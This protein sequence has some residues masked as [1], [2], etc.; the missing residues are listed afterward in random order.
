MAIDGYTIVDVGSDSEWVEPIDFAE[1]ADGDNQT[2]P[3]TNALQTGVLSGD[4]LVLTDSA[5]AL[6]S[7]WWSWT[8]ITTDVSARNDSANLAAFKVSVHVGGVGEIAYITGFLFPGGE[9]SLSPGTAGPAGVWN[10]PAPLEIRAEL[11]QA[12]G[13]PAS[14]RLFQAAFA[15]A[16][17]SR[18]YFTTAS[19]VHSI[20][21]QEHWADARKDIWT[22]QNH[23]GD[24]NGLG[25]LLGEGTDIPYPA[26]QADWFEGDGSY[27]VYSD[28]LVDG[29]TYRISA[30][31]Y[32]DNL[33]TNDIYDLEDETRVD[34]SAF[35][36]DVNPLNLTF[37]A[38]DWQAALGNPTL[39]LRLYILGGDF[40]MTHYLYHWK[41]GA[42]VDTGKSLTGFGY[43]EYQ[44]D[45]P[46]VHYFGVRT[47][48]LTGTTYYSMS[49]LDTSISIS[50]D[51]QPL[52]VDHLGI[53]SYD[54]VR[55]SVSQEVVRVS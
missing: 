27:T 32:T 48:N 20:S 40:L 22:W 37:N 54:V 51:F 15:G 31:T 16:S 47:N 1:L 42:W 26:I 14:I 35:T 38:I 8:M 7:R 30:G 23:L 21:L 12:F 11:S 28:N 29:S 13:L 4:Q 2:G 34:E 41:D 19:V 44:V 6:P 49:R 52:N 36:W 55:P 5:G 9:Q 17:K 10:D 3:E 46:G 45:S 39:T 33:G 24:G 18:D 53:T 50:V 25:V 43:I